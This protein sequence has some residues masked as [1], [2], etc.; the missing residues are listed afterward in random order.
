MKGRKD[1]TWKAVEQ[2]EREIAERTLLAKR[3]IATP[4]KHAVGVLRMDLIR[5]CN[6]KLFEVKVLLREEAKQ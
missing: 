3:E 5:E 4:E 6:R 2:L 1:A